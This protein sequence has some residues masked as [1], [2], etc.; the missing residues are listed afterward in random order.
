LK[1]SVKNTILIA[2]TPQGSLAILW[3]RKIETSREIV[4]DDSK[5]KYCLKGTISSDKHLKMKGI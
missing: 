2:G 5:S 1:G 4:Y 3:N